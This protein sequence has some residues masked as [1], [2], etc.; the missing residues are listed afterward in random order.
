[1]NGRS[2]D[3]RSVRSRVSCSPRRAGPATAS[4]AVIRD[5]DGN[6]IEITA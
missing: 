1:M 5:P 6:A 2:I 4:E 3:W